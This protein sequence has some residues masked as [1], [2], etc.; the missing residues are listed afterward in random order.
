M[1]PPEYVAL[2]CRKGHVAVGDVGKGSSLEVEFC[3]QCGE[4]TISE[5]E[6]CEW[7]IRGFGPQQWMGGPYEKPNFCGRCGSAHPWTQ[8]ALKAAKG[9][10]DEQGELT[11]D[12]K[13]ELKT[14]IDEMTSDTAVTPVAAGKFKALIKK[15][16]PQARELLKSIVSAVVT[17][18]AKKYLGLP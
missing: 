5:C 14:S 16:G 17:A 12:E 10:T 3:E 1:L 2:I 18:E 9:L 7:P 8:R 11:P 15:I 13:E 6:R 4:E